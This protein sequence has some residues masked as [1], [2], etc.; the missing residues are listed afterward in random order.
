MGQL[1]G[2]DNFE[3]PNMFCKWTLEA[4]P[5]FRVLQG[6]SSGQTQCDM[7]NVTSRPSHA[8][9]SGLMYAPTLPHHHPQEGEGA[10]WAHPLDVHYTLKSIDGWPRLL[11]S[12]PPPCAV[13]SQVARTCRPACFSCRVLRAV[14]RSVHHGAANFSPPRRNRSVTTSR[15]APRCH[16][17]LSVF[18][19]SRCMASTSMAGRNLVPRPPQ[20]LPVVPLATN[21]SRPYAR[22]PID[23]P[24]LVRNRHS[25]LWAM[26][27][28]DVSGQPPA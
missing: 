28:P 5:N 12:P 6:E 17:R 8:T 19:S 15:R 2:A 1:L 20:V 22:T 7:P 11:V 23:T 27:H 25:G 24:H 16:P 4:G 18:F 13:C 10:V 21:P 14:A 9:P 26:H 3:F